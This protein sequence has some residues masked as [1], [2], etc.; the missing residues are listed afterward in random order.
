MV[1]PRRFKENIQN[2][3]ITEEMLALA[4]YSINKRAKNA[5]DKRN[6]Y[7]AELG[8]SRSQYIWN[9]IREYEGKMQ[10]YYELKDDMLSIVEP[11][12]IHE[13]EGRHGKEYFFYYEIGGY[14]FHKPV[15][16]MAQI[17][18]NL[19]KNIVNIGE[20]TTYGHTINDLLSVQFVESLHALIRKGNFE[21][22]PDE[23]KGGE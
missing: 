17:E 3:R 23:K 10:Y 11:T 12:C 8:F 14:K 21:Y 5:R 13:S 19:E 2:G 22:I 6:Q 1:T 9:N 7:K 16:D 20:L 15:Q 18:K 4:L